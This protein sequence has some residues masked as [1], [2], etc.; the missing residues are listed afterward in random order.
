M[1]AR[2]ARRRFV[3][4]AAPPDTQ[5]RR[6]GAQ[7][8]A[9]TLLEVVI[10]IAL[11]GMLMSALMMFYW[12]TLA[13]RDRVVAQV[14]RTQLVQQTLGRMAAELR[15]MLGVEKLGYPVQLFSADRRRITF[16]TEVLP[17]EGTYRYFDETDSAAPQQS[18]REVT[19]QL[20]IDPQNTGEG[21]EPIVGGLLRSERRVFD[22]IR[23]EQESAPEDQSLYVRHELVSHEL[24]Y[25]E[26]RFFDG[27]QWTTTWGGGGGLPQQ[28]Q[29]TIGF[30]TLTREELEDTD[31]NETTPE[32]FPLGP[33]NPSP[34]RSSLIVQLRTADIAQRLQNQM[35]S[36]MPGLTPGGESGLPTGLPGGDTDN[37]GT[38]P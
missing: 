19:W 18:L 9:L 27:T 4:R 14:N 17:P 29:I 6:Y 7:R 32:Q 13:V 20:W 12:Q 15:G 21:G 31:L 2:A 8:R 10:S 36:L 28:M 1:S 33:E 34:Q 38:G 3:R 5:V 24:G 30:D 23:T 37:E 35:Q 25:L 26:F 22:P 16:V 11:I